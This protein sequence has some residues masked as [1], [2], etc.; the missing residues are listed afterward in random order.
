M[1]YTITEGNYQ[2]IF[3]VYNFLNK[4]QCGL[5]GGMTNTQ[6]IFNLIPHCLK[7]DWCYCSHSV[8]YVGFQL[9]KVIDLN[10]VDNVVFVQVIPTWWQKNGGAPSCWRIVWGG[11]WGSS[12][13]SRMSKYECLVTVSSEKKNV[14][15][16]LSCIKLAH[17]FN[18][19]LPLCNSHVTCGFRLPQSLH[20]YPFKIPLKWNIALSKKHTWWRKVDDASVLSSM[21]TVKFMR[22]TW[23]LSFSTWIIWMLYALRWSL[24]HSTSCTVEREISNCKLAAWLNWRGILWNASLM[25]LTFSSEIRVFPGDFTCNGLPVVLSLLFQNRML[26][27]FSRVM[28]ILHSKM[29]LDSRKRMKLCYPQHALNLFLRC[30][31]HYWAHWRSWISAYA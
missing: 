24:L 15:I 21:S 18:L 27:L 30:R 10:L 3:W 13:N 22:T 26:F 2:S 16:N 23:S 19:G 28:S 17:V 6:T 25:R 11:N 31:S 4:F 1:C 20:L 8:P 7:H 12:W 14:P 5:F 9:L 29:T